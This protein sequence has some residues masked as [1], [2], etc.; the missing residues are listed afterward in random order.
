M[1]SVHKKLEKPNTCVCCKRKYTIRVKRNIS[2]AEEAP[3]SSEAGEVSD[4]EDGYMDGNEHGSSNQDDDDFIASDDDL[5]H[6]DQEDEDYVDGDDEDSSLETIED[7]AS[8]IPRGEGEIIPIPREICPIGMMGIRHFACK[9]C[10]KDLE[11]CPRCEDLLGRLDDDGC[12]QQEH[13]QEKKCDD[14]EDP[15]KEMH[16]EYVFE[17]GMAAIQN[18]SE[19]GELEGKGPMKWREKF[20]C[21]DIHGGFRPSTKLQK[22]TSD[23]AHVPLNDKVLIFSLFKGSLDMLERMLADTYPG[24]EVLRFDGDVSEGER[25]EVLHKF[26]TNQACRALLMTVKTG[27]TGL[28]LVEANHVWFAE[29][30]CMCSFFA[31][32]SF[33]F[34]FH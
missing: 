14:E 12:S 13:L 22:I 8:G 9:S 24:L 5:S 26:K 18:A 32:F 11:K 16:A 19:A 34:D 28:N 29:R 7:D 20:Y 25:Q 23:F 6:Y 33:V 4:E 2:E 1:A 3:D 21:G 10:L 30:H 27:G 15:N 17:N 31:F